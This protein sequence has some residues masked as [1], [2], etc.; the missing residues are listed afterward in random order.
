MTDTDDLITNLS[1]GLE[2]TRPMPNIDLAAGLWLLASAAW[3]IVVTH[4]YGPI[5]PNALEQ[6]AGNARYL[7]ETLCGV[8]AIV[9]VSL[10]AFRAAVPGRLSRRFARWS[11]GL[12]LLW[13]S[14]YLLDLQ[15]PA[16]QP[17]MLG[18]R[19]GCVFETLL[20]A[21][22]PMVTGFLVVR[23]LYPLQPV[24]TAL[25]FSLAAGMLPALY[26]QIA[27]MYLPAHILQFHLLPGLVVAL[28]GAAVAWL[29]WRT[30]GQDGSDQ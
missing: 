29:L 11:V 9:L 24:L 28:L 2:P 21:L 27:C 14:C 7:L 16:L 22:P 3:V 23:R 25:G 5:R 10:A 30:R 6:L 18:K 4:W 20:Y 19:D 26:M 12:T 13:L 8:A 15:Y 17:S 1:R